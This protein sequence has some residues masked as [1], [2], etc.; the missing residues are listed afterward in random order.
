M[1]LRKLK[2]SV[3]NVK[4]S[5]SLTKKQLTTAAQFAKAFDLDYVAVPNL[6]SVNGGIGGSIFMAKKEVPMRRKILL[7]RRELRPV[8][9][10]D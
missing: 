4:Y 10:T 5:G 3:V 9:V 6:L 2:Q 8:L 7:K 1:A